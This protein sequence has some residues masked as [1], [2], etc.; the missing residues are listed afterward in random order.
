MTNSP[1]IYFFREFR[2][3]GAFAGNSPSF[4]KVF[5][6]LDPTNLQF[7]AVYDVVSILPW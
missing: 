7:V 1:N 4:N 6:T 2:Q 3:N 5:S